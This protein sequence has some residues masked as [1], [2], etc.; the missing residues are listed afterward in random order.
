LTPQQQERLS[1]LLDEY[2]QSLEDGQPLDHTELIDE[3]SSLGRALGVYLHD[4]DALHAGL[5][6]DGAAIESAT[7]LSADGAATKQLGD[8]RLIREI[9]RGGMGVVYEAQQISLDRRVALKILPFAALLDEKQIARFRVEARA[10]AQLQHSHIVPVYAI[11]CERGVHYY[12]MQLINGQPLD[13]AIDQL[14]RQRAERRRG[15]AAPTDADSPFDASRSLR[16]ERDYFRLVARLGA[17]AAEGLHCAHE[18]GVVHRDIKPSNL[19][20]DEQGQVWIT[21]FGLARCQF[22]KDLTRTGEVVGTMRY[23]SPEQVQGKASVDHR[24][25]V[26]SLGVTLYE[27]L[28]LRRAVRGADAAEIVRQLDNGEP[29]RPRACNAKIPAD[30]ENIVLKAMSKQRDKRYESAD[31]LAADLRRFLRGE[32]ALARQPSRLAR[33]VHWTAAHRGHAIAATLLLLFAVGLAAFTSHRVAREQAATADANFRFD[34]ETAAHQNSLALLK[35]QSG[36]IDEAIRLL[37]DTIQRQ[38]RLLRSH[39]DDAEIQG[40]LATTWSHLSLTL[41]DRDGAAAIRAAEHSLEL[42]TVASRGAG[43]RPLT[44][45][46]ANRK[47]GSLWSQHGDDHR[48]ESSYLAAVEFLRSLPSSD[49]AQFELAVALNNLGMVQRRLGAADSAASHLEAALETHQQFA[50]R[51]A[52][53]LTAKHLSARGAA[54]HNYARLLLQRGEKTI[55]VQH[56]GWAVAQQQAAALANPASQEYRMLLSAHERY[57]RQTL[58][59]LPADQSKSS[60]VAVN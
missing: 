56:F 14:R 34:R 47:L 36:E 43:D 57:R 45:G 8:F 15:Q 18:Y 53:R 20:L 25:D 24:A 40:E 23:M 60:E 16:G 46:V 12:A 54:H 35:Y 49:L 21:D 27:L 28:T 7:G 11:G 19:L 31:A 33:L 32:P 10:A 2:L 37:R 48:A 59:E 42:L 13:R 22:A 52:G 30:L 29:H 58:A 50:D 17:Q 9:G 44:L 5:V 1:Q 6:P 51:F 3:N 39:G 38:Q 41:A 55:A 26:Y 4:I